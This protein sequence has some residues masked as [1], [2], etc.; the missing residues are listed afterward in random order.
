[1]ISE[2]DRGWTIRWIWVVINS[3][4]VSHLGKI[5][6]PERYVLLLPADGP[7]A[8]PEDGQTLVD[9]DALRAALPIRLGTTRGLGTSQVNQ[10]QPTVKNED[11]IHLS[12][13]GYS[14][15]TSFSSVHRPSLR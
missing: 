1:M 7:D 4:D 5:G 15:S 8:S 14:L 2:I 12:K 6:V 10:A 9:V 3:R 11:C 13:R